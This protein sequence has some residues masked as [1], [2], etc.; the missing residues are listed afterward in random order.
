MHTTH[1]IHLTQNNI[2]IA[3]HASERQL[4]IQ[5][6]FAPRRFAA[7]CRHQNGSG[8]PQ[9]KG[10]HLLFGRLLVLTSC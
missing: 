5:Q 9:S 7:G 2:F 3:Q 1:L 10:E 6:A 8:L 4:G